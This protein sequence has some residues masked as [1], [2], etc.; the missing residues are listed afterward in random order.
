LIVIIVAVGFYT[1]KLRKDLVTSR[2]TKAM[3][4]VIDVKQGTTVDKVCEDLENA[5]IISDAFALKLYY[6][7]FL[8]NKSIKYGEYRFSTGMTPI[9]IIQL[10]IEGN[11]LLHKLTVPEGLSLLEIAQILETNG[12]STIDEFMKIV[13]S[14]EKIS[15]YHIDGNDM[16]GYLFPETY[17]FH[18]TVST[19]EVVDT[20]VQ[21]CRTVLSLYEKPMQ[22]QGL[23]ERELLT[24]ASLIE[25]EG[26]KAD[27]RPLIS[28]VFHNRLKKK[29]LLQCDPTVIYAMGDRYSG[30]I[31]KK[32]LDIDSP[33]NTYKY[34]G[35]PPGPIACP[36]KA[37][38]NAAVYPAPVD[39]LY[40]VSK[41]DGTH[42]FSRILQDH[43][44]AVVKYQKNRTK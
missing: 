33:Y 28:A 43:N 44:N 42:Q 31:Q 4:V 20:M 38:I 16:E 34:P 40:F 36:G 18:K 11:V 12:I 2:D 32:D 8:S 7:I 23:T 3:E 39:Y 1:F 30:R 14:P 24:L 41:N 26:K 17:F 15:A 13:R 37:A 27:E 21:K 10:L 6:R 22:E 9:E 35:L 25:E 29:M 19:E 5:G